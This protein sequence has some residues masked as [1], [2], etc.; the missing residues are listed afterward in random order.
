MMLHSQLLECGGQAFL[1]GVPAHAQ[2]IV[3]VLP[4]RHFDLRDSELQTHRLQ[5]TAQAPKSSACAA[6]A[7]NLGGRSGDMR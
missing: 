6:A 1:A 5:A 2:H 4:L 7:W 3:K